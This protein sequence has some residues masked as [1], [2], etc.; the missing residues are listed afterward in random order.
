MKPTVIVLAAGLGTRMRS[1]LAKALHPL[2]G[3]P[4]LQHVLN[5]AGDLSPDRMVIVVGHQGDRVQEAVSGYQADFAVQ[6]EQLGTGHAVLQARE[7]IAAAQ[8]PV[9]VLCAD[10]PLL[11]VLTLQSLIELHA[12]SRSAATLHNRTCRGPLRVRQNRPV[13]SVCQEDRRRE[14]CQSGPEEDYGSERRYL[15]L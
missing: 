11:T 7:A 14:G 1:G 13:R 3:R 10:T 4:L 9:M 2:A 6:K 15:L 5:A 12:R 8:G